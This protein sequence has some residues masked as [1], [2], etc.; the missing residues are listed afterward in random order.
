MAVLFRRLPGGI[1][2]VAGG[3][4]KHYLVSGGAD[5][6]A[7]VVNIRGSRWWGSVSTVLEFFGA[8]AGAGACVMAGGRNCISIRSFRLCR[9][10]AAVPSVS[11]VGLA[12][13]TV[14]YSGVLSNVL[15]WRRRLKNPQRNFPI[16]LAIV[17]PAFD[18]DVFYCRRWFRWAAAGK[19]GKSGNTAYLP[20]AGV[21]IGRGKR[22]WIRAAVAAMLRNGSN[23]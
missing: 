4:W 11:A 1:F 17:V 14:L 2:S 3:G 7:G 21:L 15:A 18:R 8:C 6:I 12:F 5:R 10:C 13:G 23:C 19:L 20:T 16:A 22:A 9:A